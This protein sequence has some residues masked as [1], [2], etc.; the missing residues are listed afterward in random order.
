MD[1]TTVP[2]ADAPGAPVPTSKPPS[3]AE[4][5]FLVRATMGGTYPDPDSTHARW[6]E[7]GDVFSV[8]CAADFSFRWMKRVSA[9]DAAAVIVE[10]PVPQTTAKTRKPAP[11]PQ[12]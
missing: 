9:D 6:R 1:T 10:K 7:I 4:P 11:F 5:P 12:M 2:I 8:K 3:L